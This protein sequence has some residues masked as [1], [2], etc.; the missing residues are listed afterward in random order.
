MSTTNAGP[1]PALRCGTGALIG[2]T[3]DGSKVQVIPLTCKSWSCPKCGPRKQASWAQRIAQAEPQRHIVLTSDPARY[4]TCLEALYAMKAALPALS[5]LIRTKLGVSE[6]V[7]A[8]EFTREGWPHIHILQR[9]VY[10]PQK[11]LSK[12]WDN[13]GPGPV[14]FLRSIHSRKQAAQ[15]VTK[16]LLKSAGETAAM[17][18]GLRIL[19]ATRRFFPEEAPPETDE[20]QEITVWHYLR[21]SA[22]EVVYKLTSRFKFEVLDIDNEDV[23]SLRAP[24]T[25]T[26]CYD[27][28]EVITILG[29]DPTDRRALC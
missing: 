9:G 20:T 2:S 11:W 15:Y 4:H 5:K 28:Q 3:P 16:Y 22:E 25:G 19:T 10:I 6:H 27:T 18:P 8:F 26:T 29:L 1:A 13:L 21:M 12:A 14:V 7:A 24:P 23:V 17:V